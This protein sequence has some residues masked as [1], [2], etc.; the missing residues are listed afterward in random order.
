M[1]E[2]VGL[3]LRTVKDMV[4]CKMRQTCDQPI[5]SVIIPA[6]N[7]T[8]VIANAIQSVLEQSFQEFEIIVVDDGSRDGMAETVLRMAQSEPRIRL[9][10]HESNRGAQAAR[11]TGIRAALG[12]WIAFLDSDDTWVPN[13][14]EVR[15]AAARSRNVQVVHSAGFLLRFGEGE[16]ETF[17]VPALS[18]NVYRQL[19]RAPGPLFP[20][21]LVSAKALG[22]IGGL[23]EALIAYQEWDTAIRLARRFE[24][25]FVP[26]PTFVYDCRGTDTISKNLLRG[27]KGYEQIVKNHLPEIVLKTS[28]RALAEHYARLS[29]EYRTAGDERAS[30]RCKRISYLWWPNPCVPVRKLRAVMTA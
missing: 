30:R 22:A 19:L 17:E 9:I 8:S 7:R 27:A 26:E 2:S 10:R 18:G 15:M 25:A 21:L 23:D 24:F 13:S 20:A 3:S 5:V 1:G 29:S 14:L 28:P 11:N 4:G 16:R 12:E 6:F